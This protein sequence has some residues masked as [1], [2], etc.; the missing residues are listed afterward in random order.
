MYICMYIYLF[1]TLLTFGNAKAN[2]T[3]IQSELL[4]DRHPRRKLSGEVNKRA[5]SR[6][7]NNASNL[8]RFSVYSIGSCLHLS[9]RDG[10]PK[11]LDFELKYMFELLLSSWEFWFKYR[12]ILKL[13]WQNQPILIMLL[14]SKS[15]YKS[16]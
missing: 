4:L 7:I 12:E 3:C 14:F 2:P 1:N 15:D 8:P 13:I 10:F 9:G 16:M 11:R 6:W 5:S